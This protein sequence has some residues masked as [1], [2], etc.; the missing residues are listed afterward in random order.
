MMSH[1][2]FPLPWR[3]NGW[4]YGFSATEMGMRGSFYSWGARTEHVIG[5]MAAGSSKELDQPGCSSNAY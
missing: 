1:S 4:I 2:S 5:V 3:S